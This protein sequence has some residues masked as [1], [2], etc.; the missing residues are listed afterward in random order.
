MSKLTP[1]GRRLVD[2]LAERHDFGE[3][4]VENVLVAMVAGHGRMAQFAHP[5]LG[6]SG[7]WMSGGML[8]I[9][10]MFDQ[11]LKAR[12]GRL[13]ADLSDGLGAPASPGGGL[14]SQGRGGPAG[15]HSGSPFLEPSGSGTWWPW[16]LG[17]PDASGA[18]DSMRY[19]YFAAAC[20][21]VV[22]AAGEMRLH[23]T[24]DHRIGGFSQRRGGTDGISMSS[25]HG[26]VDLGALPVVS[27]AGREDGTP[28][29]NVVD[30]ARLAGSDASTG[31]G[32]RAAPGV[33]A[34]GDRAANPVPKHPAREVESEDPLRTIER[35][36]ELRERGVLSDEE[37]AAKKRELLA[38]L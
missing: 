26:N 5:E 22:E 37:F 32:A 17:A 16:D 3:E 38:R 25:Q 13:C 36:G 12:V 1:E 18:Q 8:M 6:G 10:N 7:Q 20:R 21:L 19:A 14:Q 24:L 33:V 28:S 2:E 34:R 35:L 30:A 4:A 11:G 9:G 23:D 15:T 31:R 29:S 27:V